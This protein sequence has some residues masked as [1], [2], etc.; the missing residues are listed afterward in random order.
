MRVISSIERVEATATLNNVANN[1][2]LEVEPA[3]INQLGKTVSRVRIEPAK[4]VI[5]I[6]VEQR[7]GYSNA[8]VEANVSLSPQ[9]L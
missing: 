2:E 3:A 9:A 4:Q 5:M 7:F 6:G 8:N 1:V